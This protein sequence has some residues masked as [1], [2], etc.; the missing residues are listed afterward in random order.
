MTPASFSDFG[1][2]Q[3]VLA[4]LARKGFEEPTLI[5]A[6]AIPKLMG[7][8]A[9]LLARARTGTG[10]TAAFGLPLVDRLASP[11]PKVRALVLVPTR[12]LALQVSGEISSLA[13]SPA[14]RVATVYGGASMGE[15]L[16]RLARGVDIVVGTPGRVLD[17]IDRHTLDLSGL[18]WLVLDEA[19]EM[20]DMG[21]IEDIE[22][23]MD[24]SNPERRVVLF[25]ATMPAPIMR[26]ARERLGSFEQVADETN[27]VQA[28]LTD[29]IWLEVRAR[30]KLEALCR[31]VDAEDEFY[32]LVFCHTKVETDAVARALAD[33]GYAAEAL[34]GD[35][36]QDM[37]E[38]ILGRFRDRK[39]LILV[40]TDVA[41]RGIDVER[42]SHVVNFNL[43]FDP[44]MYT[45]RIGRT[46]R[47][48]NKGTAIT[49]VTPEEYRRL[50]ALRRTSGAGLRKGAVPSVAEVI[51][52]K[53]S[54]IRAKALGA[55]KD[56]LGVEPLVAADGEDESTDA[57]LATDPATEQL[58]A[59]AM[60]AG[61][62]GKSAAASLEFY[63]LADELLAAMQPRDAL[64]ALAAAAFSGDLDP[65]RYGEVRD[66][67]V[68]ATG[69]ARLY[70]GLG[71]RDGIWPKDIVEVV[72]KL[73]G[74]SDRMI[75]AIEVLE[76]FS[77][78]TVPFDA[79][80]KA[81]TEARR[82]RR[83]PFMRLAEPKTGPAG[84]SRSLGS[85]RSPGS[86]KPV[87]KSAGRYPG[88]PMGAEHPGHSFE[89]GSERK[90]ASRRPGPSRRSG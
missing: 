48:G 68:D 10:K 70:I 20:L 19:D 57:M 14:P 90:P 83:Y 12:E 27:P 31:I 80:E 76:R 63:A 72:K 42:L 36:S 89:R 59:E 16:R 78:V 13:G 46:G 85:G 26:I 39:T 30:D 38:R 18:E 88:K 34:H 2:S 24:A 52:A 73:T 65:R 44:E 40:A 32:G 67:S 61:G 54:R 6:L 75:D 51:G 87:S 58:M 21:F 69:T 81:I 56:F 43:P 17:H 29:Q 9:H 82:N 23:V 49:F 66:I 7:S 15:Q 33:R 77:F 84:S 3:S 4:A 5:Q 8:T 47:A 25:S 64:A 35:V 60:Q 37:R 22:R 1:L 55:A 11:G 86:G 71:K 79:A 74:L 62:A 41:A 50:F 45:H 53:R 28:G